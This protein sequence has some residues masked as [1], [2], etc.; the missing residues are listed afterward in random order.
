MSEIKSTNKYH[1]RRRYKTIGGVSYPMDEYEVILIEADSEDCGYIRPQYQWSA[2]TGYLCDFETYT[3]YRREVKMV[4]YDSGVTWSVANPLEERR[5]EV[6]AYDSY[7]C[8]KPMYRCVDTGE[9]VCVDNGDDF[10]LAFFYKSNSGDTPDITIPCEDG[11]I[12]GDDKDYISGSTYNNIGR[13]VVGD[14]VTEIRKFYYQYTGATLTIG[15]YVNKI[16]T[17]AIATANFNTSLSDP[18]ILPQNV[19]TLEEMYSSSSSAVLYIKPLRDPSSFQ[20]KGYGT[21]NPLAQYNIFAPCETASSWLDLM[22]NQI[23]SGGTV[24]QEPNTGYTE[25]FKLSLE[26]SG[27]TFYLCEDDKDTL[28]ADDLEMLANSV[29]LYYNE[30]NV[31]FYGTKITVGKDITKLTTDSL[32][33]DWF[34][35]I[36]FLSNSMLTM[37]GNPFSGICDS[38][39][40]KIHVKCDTFPSYMN[41][42]EW[43]NY[44]QALYPMGE[45]CPYHHEDIEQSIEINVVSGWSVGSV[46]VSTS[47]SPCSGTRYTTKNGTMYITVQGYTSISFSILVCGQYGM[48]SYTTIYG[49]D[50]ESE[51]SYQYKCNS[52]GTTRRWASHTLKFSTRSRQTIKITGV[53]NCSSS[54]ALATNQIVLCGIN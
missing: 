8:G 41:S 42:T 33:L 17:E 18:I 13:V 11:I 30:N 44:K 1:I 39:E 25:D 4:S 20:I 37:I 40:T 23:V 12:D 6:I 24:W 29:R 48:C 53:S 7:D 35:D 2:T 54:G 9:R 27:L 34:S 19:R 52:G 50:S 31:N 38:E 26:V 32:Y 22:S 14:C 21:Q 36:T 51:I 45:S 49:E 46:S 16:Y 10:K 5:G 43:T 15:T 47:N 3:K 28:Y